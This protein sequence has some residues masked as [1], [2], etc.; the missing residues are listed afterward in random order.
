MYIKTV[1]IKKLKNKSELISDIFDCEKRHIIITGKNGTGKS[2]LLSSI[3][4]FYINYRHDP[5]TG[6][7]ARKLIE[8]QRKG[9]L[10][11]A[12]QK[13]YDIYSTQLENYVAVC[14]VFDP[15]QENK[16]SNFDPLHVFF[17]ARR[18]MD[19]VQPTGITNAQ[20]SIGGMG[21]AHLHQ[22][23]LQYIVN[24]RAQMS[25]ARDDGDEG[26]ANE[27]AKWFSD[28]NHSL[29]ELFETDS[30]QLKFDRERFTFTIHQVT[31]EPYGFHQLSDGQSAALN[32]MAELVLQLE[33]FKKINRPYYGVVFIDELETHL[34]VG[35]QKKILPFLTRQF[36]N[37][38]FVITTHSP[39]VLTSIPETCIIDLDRMQVFQDFS[40]YSYEAILED[41]FLTDKYSLA[42]KQRLVGIEAI[43]QQ[44]FYDEAEALLLNLLKDD[45]FGHERSPELH[46]HISELLL[47]AREAKL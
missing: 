9:G 44:G 41:F 32:I 46:H 8:L 23:F 3:H 42:L 40:A 24:L 34:H 2:T 12:E 18:Q 45:Q 21:D 11:V 43:I 1:Y 27:I 47:N 33:A 22:Q 37:I 13:E 30:L 26:R 4:N 36:P 16:P 38:Q 14:G 17:H 35:L 19:P 39:F 6:I 15:L 20:L 31:K 7:A 29:A 5:G 28:L 10:S 25:F